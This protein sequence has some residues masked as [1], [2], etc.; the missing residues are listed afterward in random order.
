MN[1]GTVVKMF[2]NM[3]AIQ[4]MLGPRR[5][6]CVEGI[7]TPNGCDD[8]LDQAAWVAQPINILPLPSQHTAKSLVRK[9]LI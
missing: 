7:F 3:I 8:Q 4:A 5:Y 6:H 9:K 2:W 1:V